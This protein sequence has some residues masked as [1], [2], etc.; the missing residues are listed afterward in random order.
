[1][2]ST[3]QP[4]R[5]VGKSIKRVNDPRL[6]TG[7]GSFVDDIHLPGTLHAA[8][9]RSPYAHAE[10]RGIDAQAA[11][12][13]PGVVAVFSGQDLAEFVRPQPTEELPE[14]RVLRRYPLSRDHARFVGD[15]VAVVLADDPYAAADA[16]EQL[17]VDY[18][19]LPAVT[20]VEAGL[21]GGGPPLFSR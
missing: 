17:Q 5:Y 20:D 14:H 15:L 6:V 21:A 11:L 13:I 1:M 9:V 3:L 4:G 12:A 2:S 8:M 18:E 16:A 19:P 7:A 10:I